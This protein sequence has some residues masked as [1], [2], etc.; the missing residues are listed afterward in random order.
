M[1]ILI[2]KNALLEE[3]EW[4]LSVVNESSKDEIRDVIQRIENAPA[5]DAVSIEQYEDLREDF[6]DF[7]CSGTNNLAPYCKNCCDECVDGRGW[8]TYQRCR[9]FNPDGRTYD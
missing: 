7:V 6:V 3:F 8:C 5:I 4:L 9:G 1:D 2:S